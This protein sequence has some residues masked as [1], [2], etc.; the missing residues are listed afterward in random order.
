MVELNY[1]ECLL[2]CA[3]QQDIDSRYPKPVTTTTKLPAPKTMPSTTKQSR[4]KLEK[5]WDEHLTNLVCFK[6]ERMAGV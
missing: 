5:C 6:E 4:N 3:K 1:S 2:P